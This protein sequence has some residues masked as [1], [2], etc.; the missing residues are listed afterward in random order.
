M[1]LVRANVECKV[2]SL[3]LLLLSSAKLCMNV[4][5]AGQL[6]KD[7]RRLNVAFSRAMHKFIMVGSVSTFEHVDPMSVCVEH[8]RARNW[9]PAGFYTLLFDRFSYLCMCRYTRFHLMHS[10]DLHCSSMTTNLL[11]SKSLFDHSLMNIME[12]HEH[13]RFRG[14]T[15]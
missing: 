1:S 11:Y 4:S 14:C 2:S 9:V 13:K 7:P 10:L 3:P 5:Q 12:V 6:L 15:R 8:C